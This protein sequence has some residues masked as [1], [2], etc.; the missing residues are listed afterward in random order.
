M[1][2]LVPT[3]IGNLD[4]ITYRAVKVLA[5]VDYILSEDTRTTQSLL[6]HY[7]ISN[8]IRSFHDHNEHGRLPSVIADLK[9]GKEIALVSEAGMPGIS[10]PGFLLVRACRQ[11]GLELTVL[12]G[13]CALVNAV[14]ASGI[15]TEPFHFEGFLPH[16]KGRQTRLKYLATL[17]HT[18]ILYESPHRF[19]KCL[20]ELITYCGSERPIAVCRELTKK[21]EEVHTGSL[22]DQKAFYEGKG[23][24]KG[25]FV[26]VVSGKE[27]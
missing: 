1:L 26:I 11:E 15:P 12:P 13:A 8:D 3:P 24:V 23:V 20:D 22:M 5:G 21:F 4:D 6:G 27:G 2:Y 16:K 18:F 17:P 9:S 10:D 14:V 7:Q 25:E 19:I